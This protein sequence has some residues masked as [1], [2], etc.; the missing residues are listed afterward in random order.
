MEIKWKMRDYLESDRIRFIDWRNI[1]DHRII[2]EDFFN[3]QYYLNPFGPVDTW[4]AV[5]GQKIV[6]QYSLQKYEYFYHGEKVIGS[7]CFDVATHPDYRYQGMFTKLGFHS[8]EKAGEKNISF[9][10]GF[11]WV[12]GIAI[13]GHKKVGWTLL[14]KLK[15]YEKEVLEEY[16][17]ENINDYTIQVIDKFDTKFD[18]LALKHKQDCSI[19]LNRTGAYLNWRY[20]QKIGYNFYCYEILNEAD[21]LVGF[22]ILKLYEEQE[23]KTLHI[24]DFILPSD[25]NVYHKLLKFAFNF[26]LKNNAEKISLIV[27]EKLKFFNFLKKNNFKRQENHFIPILHVNNDKVILDKMNDLE[28]YYFTMGENDIF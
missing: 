11:P 16:K 22:F 17:S 14:G 25:E 18:L 27:N 13:P 19:M 9:S 2:K 1:V 12:N 28:D 7:L 3:W 10:L 4:V 5:D 6:G 15:V 26:A 23:H 21:Q 8:L 20:R 24:I